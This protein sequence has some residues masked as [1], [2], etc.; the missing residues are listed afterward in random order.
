MG[1]RASESASSQP[2]VHE[3]MGT[4]METGPRNELLPSIN[5]L[6]KRSR[7]RNLDQRAG[8]AASRLTAATDAYTMIGAVAVDR[9]H[10]R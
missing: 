8:R 1:R 7:S 3:E 9:K 6:L 10:G 5:G 4:G 2:A